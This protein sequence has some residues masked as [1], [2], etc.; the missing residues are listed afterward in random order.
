MRELLAAQ[1][2]SSNAFAVKLE[3]V[4]GFAQIL[5]LVEAEGVLLATHVGGETLEHLHGFPLRAVVS[6]WRG[7]F[8]V[9]W[10][11]RIEVIAI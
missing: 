5:P 7:W 6:S 8:W 2:V 10:L 3:S 9:K 1:G 11:E 4:T